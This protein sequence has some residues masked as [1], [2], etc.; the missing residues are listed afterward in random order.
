[1][2]D[3]SSQDDIPEHPT[4]SALKRQMADLQK[5]GE[6]LV[7]LPEAQLK[8]IPLENPLLDAVLA[9]RSLKSHEAIRRQ[10]QYI[11]KIM[12]HI[13]VEPVQKALDI[14]QDKSQQSKAQFHQIE[15]WRDRLI[16][17]G[18]VALEKFLEQY[19]NADRQHIRQLIRKAQNDAAKQKN[20]GGETALFRYL[21]E[22]VSR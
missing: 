2:I 14:V 9:A 20:T 4:K 21:R 11:G 3:D 6:I 1:M 16:A 10:L 5:M 19:P 8:K 12:R 17:E 13:D 22:L 18:D 15:R 7:K